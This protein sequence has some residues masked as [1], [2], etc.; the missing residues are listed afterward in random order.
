MKSISK[1]TFSFAIF[2]VFFGNIACK[3]NVSSSGPSTNDYV[4]SQA[5]VVSNDIVV[6][7]MINGEATITLDYAEM[8]ADWETFLFNNT[9]EAITLNSF[10]IV[11]TAN[12]NYLIVATSDNGVWKSAVS[13]IYNDPIFSVDNIDGG[14]TCTCAS[15]CS[16]G[17]LPEKNSKGEW[18]CTDC[19]WMMKGTECLKS[20]TASDLSSSFHFL[21]QND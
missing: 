4:E 1:F 6:G 5:I 17:C 11:S 10:G 15:K 2:T 18:T 16:E 14:S 7:K 8:K 3:K 21:N 9:G 13:L 12:G 19:S 20:V